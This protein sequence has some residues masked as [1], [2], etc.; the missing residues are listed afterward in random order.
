MKRVGYPAGAKLLVGGKRRNELLKA[1]IVLESLKRII[2]SRIGHLF[3][4]DEILPI[5]ECSLQTGKRVIEVTHFGVHT[6]QS[7]I[8]VRISWIFGEPILQ[9]FLCTCE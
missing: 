3:A 6:S 8:K 9:D 2:R 5:I 4:S 1:F 7:V